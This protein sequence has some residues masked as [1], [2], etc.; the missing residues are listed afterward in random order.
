MHE[1]L[2]PI[3]EELDVGL[4]VIGSDFD[5]ITGSFFELDGKDLDRPASFPFS[6][7]ERLLW[8]NWPFLY[9]G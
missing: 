4:R 9:R 1:E 7:G 6:D 2:E 5:L 8:T 3:D